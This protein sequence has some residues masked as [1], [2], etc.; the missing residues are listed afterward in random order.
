MKPEK[1]TDAA[2]LRRR[3][4]ARFQSQPPP[5]KV[6]VSA[7]GTQGLLQELQIHQIELEMQN[8]ELREARSR[9]EASVARYTDLYDFA[10][11][12]Y[13]TLGSA[14]EIT[15]TNLAGARLLGHDR[16]ALIGK[17]FGRFVSA[18]DRP[19][20]N[21]HLEQVFEGQLHPTCEVGLGTNGEPLHFVQ[22]QT[23]LSSAG[24][25]CRAVVVDI[26]Q[27]KR[28]DDRLHVL[29]QTLE[30]ST[31]AILV[32]DRD[33]AIIWANEAFT[34]LTGYPV[35]EVLGK[36]MNFLKS[37][38]H[39]DAFYQRLWETI[40][41][42]RVWS[43]DMVNR[44]K[45][46]SLYNEENT[47]TPVRDGGAQIAHFIAVKRDITARKQAEAALRQQEEY[48]RAL[49]E[50]AAD[51]TSV[52]DAD[53]TIRYESPSTQKVFGYEPAELV[54][55]SAFDFIH[56]EDAARVRQALVESIASPGSATRID[57]RFRHK[58]GSWRAVEGASRNLLDNPNVKG[59]VVNSR[60]VTDRQQ[61]AE[62]LRESSRFNQQ[63]VASAEEGIIVYGRD[64]KYQVWNPFMEHLTS[65]PA[66]QVLGKHPE[67][68]F[69][70][71]REVRVLDT[72]QKALAGQTT[73]AIDFP[74]AGLPSG[75]SG[76]SSNSFGPL[77]NVAGEIIGVIGI[78]RDITQ[79]KRAELRIAAF[80][81]LGQRLNSAKTAREAGEIIVEVADQL[82]GWD[83]CLFQLYSV[84]EN[85]L[86]A[87]V[88]MDIINGQRTECKLPGFPQPPTEYA[89][90]AIEQGGQLI[91]R[92]DPQTIREEGL[93]F[94][95]TSRRSA[96]IVRVPIQ[97]GTTILGVLSIQSYRP[98]AYDAQS[99]ETLQSLADHAGGALERL[100]AEEVSQTTQQR[101]G[102]LLT[103]SPAVIY[104]LKTDGK[105]TELLWVSENIERLLGYTVAECR[106]PGGLLDQIH[107]K[108]RPEVASS[109]SQLI[110]TKEIAR[111]YRV[112]HKNG[113]YHWIQDE[114]R[115][116]CDAQGAPAEIV[117]S[118]IDI[119]NRKTIEDQL[120]QAQKMEAVGQLAGGVAHDFNN[121]LAVIRGSADLAL[122]DAEDNPAEVRECLK[123]VLAASERAAGLTR[124]LLAFSRKQILQP[125]PLMLDEIIVNLTRMLQRIIGENIDMDCHCAAP[126]PYV[127]ADPGMMEQVLLNLVVN[128]R[129]AMP[130]GGQ[131]RISTESTR[132]DEAQARINP[133]AR[134]GEFVCLLVSDTGTGIAPEVL[135]RIFEPFFTTKEAGKGTGLG[136]ATLYGIVK[137]HQGW[138]EVTS[139]VGKGTTFK[140]FLPSIPVPA[141]VGAASEDSRPVAG[142]NE[143]ILLVEDDPAV[144]LTIRR[145]L[146]SKGYRVCEAKTAQEALDLW[147]R[148]AGEIALALTDLVMPG[149]LTGRDL[150][151]RLQQDNP[152]LKVIFMTGYG[153][154]IGGDQASLVNHVGRRFL[155]KPC[156]SQT[157]LETVRQCLD[158]HTN[159]ETG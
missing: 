141:R 146:T 11:V 82:L 99:L 155:Q 152:R 136:L 125:Q 29:N 25:E 30:A 54:G 20:F 48:F 90:R 9:E 10:P 121:M 66:N 98:N 107:P 74:F 15:Q 59:I 5:A 149:T 86:S 79:R 18:A 6:P 119:T 112:R 57:L 37:G 132:L 118:W 106:G 100:R 46:G 42:G 43:G 68:V 114:Q 95:D 36:K 75:K 157:I 53:G 21:S 145:L 56:P 60:D 58:D 105:T 33:G 97:H 126:L 23:T 12:G 147:Q 156:P 13:F 16:A 1:P 96:S 117:G 67:E 50:M 154:G 87:L 4:Q 120:R 113:E 148:H 116:I 84:H 14:G 133:E 127:Q 159:P 2:D 72:L 88:C 101:L 39:D 76:W 32:S 102:R 49:T 55:R 104:S 150:A 92:G 135:P 89:K 65:L 27:R 78:V 111:E 115:L 35:A 64:L 151:E 19:S 41:A 73:P 69:P 144:R 143:M 40:L 71:L 109:L 34:G 22:I 140:V 63:I 8:E 153:A 38:A 52:F 51:V 142:G 31:N 26:T 70:F 61:L 3:A 138:V 94:G 139:Q 45:D 103:Q 93:P 62:A 122:M 7:D 83:A 47:I 137:Q 129:D 108:D 81:H 124:Q 44:R 85:R 134:A 28:A 131:L 110:T 80:A 91:L 130:G 128:A 158:D 77:R 24:Q 17:R 123:H